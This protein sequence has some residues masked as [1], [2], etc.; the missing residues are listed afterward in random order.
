M[1]SS[2]HVL[3]IA[4]TCP[5]PMVLAGTEQYTASSS[6]VAKMASENTWGEGTKGKYEF[7]NTRF[8]NHSV[9]NN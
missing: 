5:G 4:A 1:T 8:M 6:G 9:T 2:F 3:M 7:I